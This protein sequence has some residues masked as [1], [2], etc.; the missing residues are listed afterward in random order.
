MNTFLRASVRSIRSLA[1]L[2]NIGK[3]IQNRSIYHMVNRNNFASNTAIAITH[4][5][6]NCKCGCSGMSKM[7]TKGWLNNLDIFLVMKFSLF[8]PAIE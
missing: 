6:M 3:T 7:H 1:I 4:P 8:S 5:S 2:P